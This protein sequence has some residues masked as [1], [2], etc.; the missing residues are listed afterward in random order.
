MHGN[1][2]AFTGHG[3]VGL[4]IGFNLFSAGS[5]VDAEQ[6]EHES[7]DGVSGGQV[8]SV[9]M[10]RVKSGHNLVL[11]TVVGAKLVGRPSEFKP[12]GEEMMQHVHAAAFPML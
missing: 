11:V 7:G 8:G 5:M 2:V 12:V 6:I 3:K 9:N 10:C 4:N 1:A